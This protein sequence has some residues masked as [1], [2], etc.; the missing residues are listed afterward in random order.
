VTAAIKPVDS[1]LFEEFVGIDG[2]FE[3][4]KVEEEE[5]VVNFD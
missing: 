3:V 1:L 2:F 4:E 5:I